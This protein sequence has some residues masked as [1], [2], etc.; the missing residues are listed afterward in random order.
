MTRA[1]VKKPLAGFEQLAE[2]A[3]PHRAVG[4]VAVL[5]WTW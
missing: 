1:P 5:V 4:T 2:V 3:A